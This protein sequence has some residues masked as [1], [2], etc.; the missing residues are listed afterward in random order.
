MSK[1]LCKLCFLMLHGHGQNSEGLGNKQNF[2]VFSLYARIIHIIVWFSFLA[3]AWKLG[4]SMCK[5]LQSFLLEEDW[6]VWNSICWTNQALKLKGLEGQNIILM[7]LPLECWTPRYIQP[8]KTVSTLYKLL[9]WPLFRALP[10]LPAVKYFKLKKYLD[11]IS[12]W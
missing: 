5:F 7:V 9:L 10:P 8:E 12:W 2:V 1:Y 6:I 4:F 3:L 11:H